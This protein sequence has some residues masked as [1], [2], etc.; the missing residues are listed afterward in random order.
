VGTSDG[1]APYA[2]VVLFA[3][4]MVAALLAKQYGFVTIKNEIDLFG[5]IG[6][7][8][9]IITVL[10]LIRGHRIQ[11]SDLIRSHMS[12]FLANE[13]LRTS[14]HDLIYSFSDD[15]WREAQKLTKDFDPK[16]KATTT[17]ADAWNALDSLNSKREMG[18][19]LYHPA[20]FQGSEEEKRLDAVLHFFDVLAYSWRNKLVPADDIAGVAGYHLAVID[21]RE[22]SRFYLD[23]NAA[24]WE[25]LPFK[26]RIGA[27]PP[28]ENLRLL[29]DAIRSLNNLRTSDLLRENSKRGA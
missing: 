22:V 2:G 1:Q 25:N 17:L 24:F 15:E 6:I 10:Q 7:P 23:I 5:L 4:L 29:L 27:E 21:T 19:R 18:H 14:F 12:T 16:I 13:T 26:K 3:F 9:F 8:A 11:A 28:F 20:F